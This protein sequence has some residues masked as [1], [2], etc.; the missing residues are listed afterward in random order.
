MMQPKT[1]GCEPAFLLMNQ[2]YSNLTTGIGFMKNFNLKLVNRPNILLPIF[3]FKH[4]LIPFCFLI[5][6]QLQSP[7]EHI[8]NFI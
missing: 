3:L 5:L 6:V 1:C 8:S 4:E 7:K 2:R